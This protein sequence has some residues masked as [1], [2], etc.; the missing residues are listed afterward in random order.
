MEPQ[1]PV[2]ETEPPA[3]EP[4]QP[5]IEPGPPP[6]EPAQP[7]SVPERSETKPNKTDAS[8]REPETPEGDGLETH[9][10][11]EFINGRWVEVPKDQEKEGTEDATI[12]EDNPASDGSP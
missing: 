9:E 4:E 7:V 8:G 1:P 12:S 5:V 3:A 10:G 2:S 11:L 6:S